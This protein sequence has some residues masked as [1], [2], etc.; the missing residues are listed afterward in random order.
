MSPAVSRQGESP[1]DFPLLPLER[2]EAQDAAV[3]GAKAATLSRLR[4][5]F[6]ERVP[7]GWVLPATAA[8]AL[9]DAEDGG[10]GRATLEALRGALKRVLGD[11]GSTSFAVRS[12]GLDEDSPQH[13]FAGQYRTIL[14]VRGADA[15]ASAVRDCVRSCSA[16]QIDAYRERA[17]SAATGAPAVLVQ[18]M[19]P[20]ERAGVAF[21]ANPVSGADEIVIDAGYGLADLVVGGEITPDGLGVDGDGRVL[22]KKIGGKR[23]MSVLT[24]DGVVRIPIPPA[25]RRRLC[26]A[27]PQIAAV[28]EAAELCRSTLGYHADVEWAIVEDATLVLQ[29][30][31]ITSGVRGRR[32][33]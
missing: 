17:G 18:E 14:G 12:S 4:R 27:P 1:P 25:F 5:S 24:A 26:L 2:D 8:T 21:T 11:K 29:A 19:V 3:A 30:R 6:P 16:P 9:L 23:R 22:W 15:V 31:P 7:P 13:S 28:A 33:P 10:D 32:E 20:A